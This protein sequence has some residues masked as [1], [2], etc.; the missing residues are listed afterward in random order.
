[1]AL[2]VDGTHSNVTTVPSFSR[3]N[4]TNP[5]ADSQS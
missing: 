5:S 2:P 1:M 4:S 3:Q